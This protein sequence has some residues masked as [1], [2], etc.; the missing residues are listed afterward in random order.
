MTPCNH[1]GRELEMELSPCVTAPEAPFPVSRRPV[2][3]QTSLGST[4][5]PPPLLRGPA[6]VIPGEQRGC[7]P[8]T[9]RSVFTSQLRFG[10]K[11][12][13][14]CGSALAGQKDLSQDQPTTT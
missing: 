11:E 2:Y 3:P 8:A 13:P 7:S 9:A 4:P 6:G 10:Q 12:R 1:P 5:K 14:C